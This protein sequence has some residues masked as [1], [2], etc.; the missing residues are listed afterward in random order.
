MRSRRAGY[1]FGLPTGQVGATAQFLWD[2][3][4]WAAGP[5]V[6]IADWFK[7]LMY[8]RYEEKKPH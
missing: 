2:T 4:R 7:G 8:G 6:D 5:A 3:R 1:V